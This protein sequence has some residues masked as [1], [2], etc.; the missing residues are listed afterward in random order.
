MVP[1][2]EPYTDWIMVISA[3]ITTAATVPLVRYAYVTIGEGKKDR[4]KDTAEKQ[5]E[6]VYTP[7]YEILRLARERGQS[8]GPSTWVI[9]KKELER[10]DEIIARFGHYFGRVDLE[11]F[12]KTLQRGKEEP[13]YKETMLYQTAEIND[14]VQYIEKRRKDLMAELEELTAA[15]AT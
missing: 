3:V 10:I 6:N 8:H 5:L 1:I 11:R 15:S 7:I 9:S 14:A 13:V 12:R 2:L 4:R